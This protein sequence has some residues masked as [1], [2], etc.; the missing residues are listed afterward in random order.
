[1]CDCEAN[2]TAQQELLIMREILL[3]RGHGCVKQD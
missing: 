2:D 3:M 1:M